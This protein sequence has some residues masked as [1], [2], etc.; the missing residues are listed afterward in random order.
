MF[1]LLGDF[2]VSG[3]PREMVLL[4]SH[5]LGPGG[6]S[7]LNLTMARLVKTVFIVFVSFWF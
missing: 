7:I 6:L 3:R 2:R 1:F 4:Q 5:D